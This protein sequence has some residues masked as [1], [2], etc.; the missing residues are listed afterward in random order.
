MATGKRGCM[1]RKHRFSLME[2]FIV[3]AILLIMAPIMRPRMLS[4]A[5]TPVRE[6]LH[7]HLAR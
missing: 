2:T 5:M 4:S 6:F 1:D 7:Q 3:V